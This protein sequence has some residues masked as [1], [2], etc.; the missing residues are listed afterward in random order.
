MK[1]STNGPIA[2]PAS[3]AP[4]DASSLGLT[5]TRSLT[6]Q[7]EDEAGLGGTD[8]SRPSLPCVPPPSPDRARLPAPNRP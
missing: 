3:P 6:G 8:A 5:G 1:M 7:S 4:T 2:S